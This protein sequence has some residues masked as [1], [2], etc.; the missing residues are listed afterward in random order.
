MSGRDAAS[1]DALSA[2]LRRSH[3]PVVR[4]GGVALVRDPVLSDGTLTDTE[5]TCWKQS[6]GVVLG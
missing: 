5:G 4:P 6:Q 1:V 3:N 2:M